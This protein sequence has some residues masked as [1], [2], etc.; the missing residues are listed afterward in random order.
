MILPCNDEGCGNL[1]V[2]VAQI[3]QT[4]SGLLKQTLIACQ[5]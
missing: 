1:D 5:A 3:G 4:L 2:C